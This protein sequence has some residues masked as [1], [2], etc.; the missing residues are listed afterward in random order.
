MCLY[1]AVHIAECQIL[2]FLTCQT[3][4]DARARRPRRFHRDFVRV[5]Q[6]LG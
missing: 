5:A 1:W 3:P 6:R 4:D 2:Q